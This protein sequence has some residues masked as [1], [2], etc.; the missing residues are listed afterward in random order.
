YDGNG[1][2]NKKEYDF[3]IDGIDSV[4]I[5]TW[6]DLSLDQEDEDI[7]FIGILF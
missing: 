4:E 7:C 5:H 6:T 3:R 1:N 2:I